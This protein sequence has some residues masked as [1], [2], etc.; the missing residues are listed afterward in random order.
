VALACASGA[1]RRWRRRRVA[2]GALAVAVA[3]AVAGCDTD[4][5]EAAGGSIAPPGSGGTLEWALAEPPRRVD[6]LLAT[7]PTEQLVARQIYEPLTAQVEAPYGEGVPVSGLASAHRRANGAV[8]VLRLRQGVTF[9][10]GTAFDAE[11]VV[12]NARRWRATAAGRELLPDLVEITAPRSHL[13]IFQLD[14]PHPRFDRVLDSPR[15]GIASP[16]SLPPRSDRDSRL[17]EPGT[18]GTGPFELTERGGGRILITR[19]L[20]W[21]GSARG[22]GPALDQVEFR[23][24]PGAD[25]RLRLLQAGA[26]QVAYDLRADQLARVRR[27][28]LLTAVEVAGDLVGLE[29]SVRGIRPGPG[30]PSLARVWLTR[31]GTA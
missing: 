16:G 26:V 7:S 15:L 21:W 25:E 1:R 18:G 13:V 17:R 9:Q 31:I 14:R 3:I 4:D 28:P 20:D 8:W 2:A 30:A 5:D 10:D 23:I 22:L 27:D 6:P 12:A 24:V 11:A 19:N 29:R